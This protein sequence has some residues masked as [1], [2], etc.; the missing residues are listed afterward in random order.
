M[1]LH[2][3]GLDDDWT[4]VMEM[5]SQEIVGS[6]GS[7]PTL[8]QEHHDQ[9]CCRKTKSS[10]SCQ[11]PIWWHHNQINDRMITNSG[12]CQLPTRWHHNQ[13]N[14]RMITNSG[15]CQLPTRWHHDQLNDRKMSNSCMPHAPI[16][17]RDYPKVTLLVDLSHTPPMSITIICLMTRTLSQ[18]I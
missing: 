6:E 17:L 10:G 4:M 12:S 18:G 8:V 1:A 3:N 5:C 14:D 16:Y 2:G 9:I 11:L 15:S 13:I 7:S